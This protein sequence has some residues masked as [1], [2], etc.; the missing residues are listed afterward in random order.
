M[1]P[2]MVFSGG[3][4][5]GVRQGNEKEN[6]AS[7][8]LPAALRGVFHAPREHQGQDASARRP[9]AERATSFSKRC[10]QGQQGI[11]NDT[12]GA[13]Q[14]VDAVDVVDPS[15]NQAGIGQNPYQAAGKVQERTLLGTRVLVALPPPAATPR[16]GFQSPFLPPRIAGL[17]PPPST[18]GRPPGG[19][20]VGIAAVAVEP[21]ALSLQPGAQ[22]R[23]ARGRNSSVEE[24]RDERTCSGKSA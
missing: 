14:V 23:N 5:K 1:M 7:A 4:K 19:A 6:W 2:S 18:G 21:H 9:L 12:R 17:A 8:F 24:R 20:E 16:A 10:S 22:I 13:H 3:P 11:N 15:A